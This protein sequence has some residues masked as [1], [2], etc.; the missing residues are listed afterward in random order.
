[1]RTQTQGW[2]WPSGSAQ[3]HRHIIL[4]T[5][6]PLS[7]LATGKKTDLHLGGLVEAT[8]NGA[9]S[10]RL[11]HRTRH[12]TS[13][14]TRQYSTLRGALEGSCLQTMFTL[15]VKIKK[16]GLQP[17]RG[18]SRPILARPKFSAKVTRSCCPRG[19]PFTAT[20]DLCPGRQREGRGE[21]AREA[22]PSQGVSLP[23]GLQ[24]LT[25]VWPLSSSAALWAGSRQARGTAGLR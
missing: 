15:F 4:I 5:Q 1:M 14:C 9:D 3:G 22:E 18:R 24:L 16:S 19:A 23:G 11:G 6:P 7:I 12:R 21:A 13:A 25:A 20:R 10:H 2:R 8:G 17:W